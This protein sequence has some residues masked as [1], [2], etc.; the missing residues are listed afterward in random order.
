MYMDHFPTFGG[1]IFS[2]A[3]YYSLIPLTLLIALRAKWDYIMRHYWRSVAR[4]FIIAIL[5]ALPVTSI[6]QFKLTGDYLY[7]YS[8][9]KTGVCITSSCLISRMKENEYY[10]FN[11]TGLQKYGIPNL[12]IMQ[13]Y[14]LV[15]KKFNKL[16]W[17]Y[18]VVNAVVIIRSLFPLP[19]TEVWSYEVDPKESHKIIGLRKFY[20]Y[21]P[22]NPGTLLSRAYD[23]EFTMFLWGSGGGVA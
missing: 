9:T 15:D 10:K 2:M 1:Y 6:L 7:V 23:F 5:I 18:D 16:K 19:I 4:G 14:R 20:V 21:Y 13:A 17:R 8:L 3:T 12:G 22:Y 11:V